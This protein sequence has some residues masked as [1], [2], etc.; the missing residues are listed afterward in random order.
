MNPL[1]PKWFSAPIP[2][3]RRKGSAVLVSYK[4]PFTKLFTTLSPATS[5]QNNSGLSLQQQSLGRKLLR[6]VLWEMNG[7]SLGQAGQWQG[8]PCA[9]SDPCREQQP[10][11]QAANGEIPPESWE[12]LKA[13]NRN[14][15]ALSLE[16]IP[17]AQDLAPSKN[18]GNS[19]S[20]FLAA[21]FRVAFLKS[22]G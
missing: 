20:P 6:A 9:P 7:A 14:K 22:L 1:K 2:G 19:W 8:G 18:K 17:S 12:K 16:E 13:S 5:P 21:M 4:V 11:N 15:A 10:G 3:A